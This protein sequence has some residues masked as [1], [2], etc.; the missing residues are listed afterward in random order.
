MIYFM[1]ALRGP[2]KK[3]ALG[4]SLVNLL[5][6]PVL[7][8]ASGWIGSGVGSE[9]GAGSKTLSRPGRLSAN[10]DIIASRTYPFGTPGH[11]AINRD[12]PGQTGTYGQLARGWSGRRKNTRFVNTG[13]EY[14]LRT[15]KP[16]YY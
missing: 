2:F 3:G 4:C 12:C 9:Q 8:L 14:S 10:R 15:D 5:V 6:N 16:F 1:E 13:V 7:I 11:G